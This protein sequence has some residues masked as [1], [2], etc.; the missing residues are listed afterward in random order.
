MF[1]KTGCQQKGSGH[2]PMAHSTQLLLTH[3]TECWRQSIDANLVVAASF[4][5]FRKAFDFVPHRTLLHKLKH[6]FN[7]EGNLSWLTDY[8]HWARV[9]VANGTRLIELYL[10]CGIL[11]GSVLGPSLFSLYT[12]DMSEREIGNTITVR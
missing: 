7:I 8:L 5:D 2:T 4:V 1:W 10:S 12:N 6:K 11:Q 3:L 9:T